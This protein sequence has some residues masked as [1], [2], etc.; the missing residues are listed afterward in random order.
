MSFLKVNT[1]TGRT[2]T[3]APIFSTGI[4][5]VQTTDPVAV[6]TITA[7][8]IDVTGIVTATQFIGNG[9][10]LTNIPGGVTPA[11]FFAFTTIS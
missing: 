10:G 7:T 11:K 3:N 2:G 5:V 4:Q 8:R 1:I 9:S 6:S